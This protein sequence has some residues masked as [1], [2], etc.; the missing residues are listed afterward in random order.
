[1]ISHETAHGFI[2]LSSLSYIC[3][4]FFVVTTK[5]LGTLK[6]D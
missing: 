1:V 6:Q 4:W 3:F 5:L 2:M